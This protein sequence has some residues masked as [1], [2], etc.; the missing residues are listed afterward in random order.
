MK[1][2]SICAHKVRSQGDNQFYQHT[3]HLQTEVELLTL[4]GGGSVVD[5]VRL[6]DA[7]DWPLGGKSQVVRVE[8]YKA[9]II[10]FEE[11]KP[12][13]EGEHELRQELG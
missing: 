7:V 10:R 1:L 12:A 2:H 11:R 6:R 4:I 5:D 8:G 3:G 9:A 13:R